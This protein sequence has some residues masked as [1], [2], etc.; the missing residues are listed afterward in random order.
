MRM[1]KKISCFN[2]AIVR[3]YVQNFTIKTFGSGTKLANITI[4]DTTTDNVTYVTM[5]NRKGLTYNGSETTLE[6]LEKIFMSADGKPRHVLVEA[7]GRVR[8]TKSTGKDGNERTYVNTTVF[9][10]EPC[11]DESKQCAILN[12][13]G[14][15][16]A[17][18]YGEASGGEPI[19]KLKLGMMNVNRDK[20]ITGVDTVT[21]V[22]HGDLADKLEYMGAEK[23]CVVSLRCDMVNSAG[24]VDRFG[25]RIGSPK[26]EIEVAKVVFVNDD[27]DE[28][29]MDNYK[30]AKRLGKG[31]VIKV[32]KSEE[33][34]PL[35]DID[36]ADLDF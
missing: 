4:R 9:S 11:F 19:A 30:K 12:V 36:E 25:D 18:K 6:G 33:S 5:F 15:I 28:D 21:V 29:D 8:E 31:E 14:V 3:G 22:A 1:S 32:K 35:D 26:R 24:E 7:T 13:T 34:D 20:D 16:D 27:I 23:G 2:K 10:L 17:I